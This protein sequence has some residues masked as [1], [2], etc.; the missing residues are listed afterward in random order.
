MGRGTSVSMSNEELLEL[1]RN[2]LAYLQS[3]RASAWNTGDAPGVALLDQQIQA[4][5]ELIAQL[6]ASGS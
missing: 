4:Q 2:R 3:A 6:L 1:A 5:E